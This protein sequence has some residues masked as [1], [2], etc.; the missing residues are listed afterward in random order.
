MV[1]LRLRINPIQRT[2]HRQLSKHDDLL[3]R[4]RRIALRSPQLIGEITGQGLETS[5]DVEFKVELIK[6]SNLGQVWSEDADT[7]MVS[8][9][10]NTLD[11]AL[12]MATS[13][14]SRWLK[15]RYGL[16]D[17]EVATLLGATITYEIA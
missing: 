7:V 8:G 5:L 17:S 6:G 13:G 9:I 11:T 1:F 14:L 15:T 4:P 3:N 10:D 2:V 12:Q 16:D